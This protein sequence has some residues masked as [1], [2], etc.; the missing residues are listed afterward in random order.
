MSWRVVYARS[1]EVVQDML[2]EVPNSF[3][4][5][6]DG[7]SIYAGRNYHRGW[8]LVAHGKSQT[9]SVEGDN[10]ELRH[11][12]KCL[13]CST[14]CFAKRLDSLIRRVKSCS[15]I[16]GISVSSSAA[17]TQATTGRSSPSHH[18]SFDHSPPASQTAAR[19]HSNHKRQTRA[20][21][22]ACFRWG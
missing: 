1:E 2:D 21:P 19:S 8:H 9:Y 14:R 22:R 11:Y 17:P 20:C 6:T 16:A 12:I 3:Q 4:Y 10:A 7:F 18:F 15:C 5:C 13:A